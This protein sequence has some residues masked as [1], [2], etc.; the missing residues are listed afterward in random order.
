MT[1]QVQIWVHLDTEENAASLA[2]KLQDLIRKVRQ[3]GTKAYGFV[4][5]TDP[6]VKDKLV[7]LAEDKKVEDIALCYLPERQRENY[8]RLYKIELSDKLRNIVFVYRN[9]KL[10]HK[11]VN[12]DAKDFGKVEEAFKSILNAQ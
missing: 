6:A 11:F 10:A 5:W 3:D 9:K 7:K 12:L 4:I 8:L 2:V 1:P